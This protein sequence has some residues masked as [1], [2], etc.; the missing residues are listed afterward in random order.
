MSVGANKTKVMF[1]E[2]VREEMRESIYGY[3]A[4]KETTSKASWRVECESK[5]LYP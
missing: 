3:S 4:G 2:E 1:E 5:L